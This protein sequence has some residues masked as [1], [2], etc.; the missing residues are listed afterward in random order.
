MI[1]CVPFF[2]GG[3]FIYFQLPCV[4]GEL[5]GLEYLYR[6][7]G[8]VFQDSNFIIRQMEIT[9]VQVAR[10]ESYSKEEDVWD[11]TITQQSAPSLLEDSPPMCA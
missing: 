4:L 7:N 2:V 3:Q 5:I 1:V 8:N 6:Q 11:W 9:D 10:S